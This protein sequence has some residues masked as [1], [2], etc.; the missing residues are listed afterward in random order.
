M[1]ALAEAVRLQ[2]VYKSLGLV[3]GNQLRL[4]SWAARA[5]LLRT[6]P[7]AVRHLAVRALRAQDLFRSGEAKTQWVSGDANPADLGTNVLTA[8]RF[9]RLRTLHD[10]LEDEELARNAVQVQD[11]TQDQEARSLENDGVCGLSKATVDVPRLERKA[12][13]PGGIKGAEHKWGRW[14]T[15]KRRQ[16]GDKDMSAY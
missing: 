11:L 14:V 2:A 5:I 9:R 3:V 7:G 15:R 13:A 6:G 10:I 16:L 4:D 1:S 12:P 8:E